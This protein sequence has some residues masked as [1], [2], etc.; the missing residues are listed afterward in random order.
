MEDF[1]YVKDE[2]KK[3]L[4]AL[5]KKVALFCATLFSISCFIYITITAYSYFYQDENT[6]IETIHSPEGPIKVIEEDAVAIVGGS[7]K[8]NDSIYE[9][10]FGN[11]KESLARISPKIHASPA[12]AQ[13]PKLSAED[14]LLNE[15]TPILSD[16][17][18]P[19]KAKNKE[20][21]NKAAA[22]QGM[23][24][25]RDKPKE[26]QGSQDLLT[27]GKADVKV[28]TNTSGKDIAAAKV[29]KRKYLRIQ[30]AAV[31]S[32][33]SADEYWKKI[34]NSNPRLFSNRKPYTEEVNLGKRGIFYRLQIGNFSDQVEAEEFCSSYISQMNKSKAD[35]IVVE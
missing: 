6:D 34:S 24:V 19:I 16:E 8:I 14:H 27:K 25:Y 3:D 1:G 5:M 4:S 18:E 7:G 2:N 33:N 26:N 22:N 13:P 12:P 20:A 21:E 35:C 28:P 11:K 17:K 30:I 31:T 10:I 15:S 29:D 32:R 23:I 9:D